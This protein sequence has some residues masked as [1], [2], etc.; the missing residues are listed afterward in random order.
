[1]VCCERLGFLCKWGL[2][3]LD[4]ICKKV[5][6]MVSLWHEYLNMGFIWIARSALTVI[7][8]RIRVVALLVLS[9]DTI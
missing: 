8:G 6:V 5:M 4:G 3:N 7:C 2:F 9:L 1:M